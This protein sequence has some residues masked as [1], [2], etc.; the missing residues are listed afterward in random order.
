MNAF[1]LALDRDDFGPPPPP[2]KASESEEDGRANYYHL[3][4]T[5]ILVGRFVIQV[6]NLVSCASPF[7]RPTPYNSLYLL[8]LL[9][10]IARKVSSEQASD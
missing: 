6:L 1:I 2:S 9:S 4:L 3:S 5:L 7:I 8:K 10:R